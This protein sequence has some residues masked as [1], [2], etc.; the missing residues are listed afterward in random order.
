MP[1]FLPVVFLC[2]ALMASSAAAAQDDLLDKI[3]R[4]EQQILEL[5]ALKEQQKI[6]VEKEEQCMKAVGRDKFCKCLADGLPREINFEQYV[7]TL[8]TSKSTLG[9]ET[10]TPAQKRAVDETLELREKCIE[11][12][13][14]K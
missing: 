14:F 7:H 10:M 8:I 12:G 5:K 13:F 6:A 2:S 4:L 3:N 1:R 11:K 9:Y